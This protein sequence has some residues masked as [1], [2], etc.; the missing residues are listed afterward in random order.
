MAI[1]ITTKRL[2]ATHCRGARIKVINHGAQ[3]SKIYP[4]EFDASCPHAA[5][6]VDYIKDY[7]GDKGL[8]NVSGLSKDKQGYYCTINSP[9][10]GQCKMVII[11]ADT[12][13]A[14][15]IK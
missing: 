9:I 2:Q 4:L 13:T 5:A 14:S 15:L 12:F 6:I 7:Y 3:N 10:T 1:V 8:D 11:G